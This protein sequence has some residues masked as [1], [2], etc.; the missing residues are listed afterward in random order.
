MEFNLLLVDRKHDHT[1]LSYKDIYLA[2]IR[3]KKVLNDLYGFPVTF[4]RSYMIFQYYIRRLHNLFQA[5]MQLSYQEITLT[6]M[7]SFRSLV[8]IQQTCPQSNPS[9]LEIV[10]ENKISLTTTSK[11]CLFSDSYC[12]DE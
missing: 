11:A 8:W 3:N 2:L 12:N 5:S 7:K 9:T 1:I 6:Y 10:N 4:Q